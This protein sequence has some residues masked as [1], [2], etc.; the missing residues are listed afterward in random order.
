MEDQK[1][2][3]QKRHMTSKKVL[4]C[5]ANGFIGKNILERFYNKKEYVIRATHFKSEPDNKFN[6]EWVRAD[7]RERDDVKR[8]MRDVDIVLQ[9]AATTTGAKDITSKPYIHVTNNAV[10]NSLLFREAFE[11]E[12]EHFI[13]PSCT[14]MYQKSETAVKEIDFNPS[15]EILPFYYGPGHTKVYLE[16]M[17]KFYANLGKTK[18]TA[19][20]HSNIYGPHDNYDLEKSH[21]FGAT[22]TKV[23]TSKDGTIR[24]WGSGEEVRDLLYIADL[25]NFIDATVAKQ[26]NNFELFNVGLGQGVKIKDLVH[27]IIE[28]SG[29]T[30]EVVHD[31]SKP[32]IPTSLFLDCSYAKEKLGW[33]PLYTLEEGIEATLQWYKENIK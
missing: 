24:V 19:I 7:L 28:L 9:F 8:V 27:K 31:L 18:F 29:K 15:D 14:I 6:V 25:L 16:N 17:C 12:V 33:Q 20:R 32:T 11:R 5:G 22:I 21:V 3:N 23:M 2:L 13:F 1:N 30:L 26:E 4:I 10:M